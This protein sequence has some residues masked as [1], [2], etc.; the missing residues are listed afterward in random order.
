MH[1]S[2][3][4]KD[5]TVQFSSWKWGRPQGLARNITSD[6][7]KRECVHAGETK[8]KKKK[9]ERKKSS[10]DS[11]QEQAAICGRLFGVLGEDAAWVNDHPEH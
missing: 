6:S 3:F 10:R 7:P 11:Q 5:E 1:L 8:K 4:S 9:K 2:L